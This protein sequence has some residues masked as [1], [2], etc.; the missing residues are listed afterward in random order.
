MGYPSQNYTPDQE[1]QD[2]PPEESTPTKTA[3]PPGYA[4]YQQFLQWK[5]QQD[6][7]ANQ[8]EPQD[9]IPAPSPVLN[10]EPNQADP[11]VERGELETAIRS[12][13]LPPGTLERLL[14]RLDDV[15]GQLAAYRAGQTSDA[16]G[17]EGGAPIPYHLHLADG[18]IIQ[19]HDGLATHI[20]HPD[21]RI[22]RVLH[23]FRA[24]EDINRG[25]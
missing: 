25:Q 23:A 2:A 22:Q 3:P 1:P 18:T 13:N 5:A 7:A 10:P 6:A 17:P 9:A 19:N 12:G 8:P 20:A 11:S 16:T 15:E 21:G 24:D 4:E 14:K